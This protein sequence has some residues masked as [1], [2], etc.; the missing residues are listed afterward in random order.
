[1][2]GNRSAR[3]WFELEKCVGSD[4]GLEMDKGC[5]GDGRG[6]TGMTSPMLMSCFCLPP[7]FYKHLD[8]HSPAIMSIETNCER[9]PSVRLGLS[10]QYR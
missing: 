9:I 5:G 1:M 2:V 4:F 7:Q 3:S 10:H 6:G 8:I